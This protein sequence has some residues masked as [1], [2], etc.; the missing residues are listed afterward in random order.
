ML[1]TSELLRWGPKPLS[2]WCE[3]LR[4][5]IKNLWLEDKSLTWGDISPSSGDE[6]LPRG[7]TSLSRESEERSLE[8][9]IPLVLLLWNSLLLGRGGGGSGPL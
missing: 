8:R 9:G 1:R 6:S 5:G 3:S 4:W 7:E 2:R